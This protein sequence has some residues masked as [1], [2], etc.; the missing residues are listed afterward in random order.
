MPEYRVAQGLC[1]IKGV[2]A[3]SKRSGSWAASF[4]AAVD[5]QARD[6]ISATAPA[7][8]HML[9][10]GTGIRGSRLSQDTFCSEVMCTS[11]LRCCLCPIRAPIPFYRGCAHHLWYSWVCAWDEQL[12][13]PAPDQLCTLTCMMKVERHAHAGCTCAA[14][15]CMA[16]S[17]I[18][19]QQCAN[20]FLPCGCRSKRRL[21]SIEW[22]VLFDRP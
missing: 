7:A 13:K 2:R 10:L 14:A 1:A 12:Q 22:M 20:A 3:K 15:D 19:G 18:L 16:T 9:H 11:G 17:I 8:T 6:L 21:P 4:Q 5:E